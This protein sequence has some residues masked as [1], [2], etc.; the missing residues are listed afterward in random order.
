MTHELTPTPPDPS[1]RLSLAGTSGLPGAVGGGMI[2]GGWGLYPGSPPGTEERDALNLSLVIDAVRRNWVRIALAGVV[3]GGLAFGISTLLA[4][5]YQASALVRVDGDGLG[6]L[7]EQK[8]DPNAYIDPVRIQSWVQAVSGLDVLR[9]AARTAGLRYYPDFNGELKA[10]GKPKRDGQAETAAVSDGSVAGTGGGTMSAGERAVIAALAKAVTVT[11]VG[12][13]GVA[14]ID[15]TAGDP[16]VAARIA[17]AVGDAFIGQ[18]IMA[19]RERRLQA[20]DALTAQRDELSAR[21]KG[22]EQNIVRTRAGSKL[23]FAETN[24]VAGGVFAN[25]RQQLIATEADLSAAQAKRQV[26]DRARAGD[27]GGELT[28]MAQSVLIQGLR[29]RRAEA[30]VEL[31]DAAETYGP[32]HPEYIKKQ[33]SLNKIDRAIAQEVE[34]MGA[35]VRNDERILQQKV[36]KLRQRLQEVESEATD[37]TGSK[38][39]LA[40]LQSEADATKVSLARLDDQID[41]V[42]AAIGLEQAAASFVSRAVAPDAP[43]FP[44]KPLIAAAAAVAGSGFAF[45][46][47]AF[48]SLRD[49]RIRTATQL[50]AFETLAGYPV[51]AS[52]P[53]EERGFDA[54]NIAINSPY[55]RNLLDLATMLG[56]GSHKV[57]S[58]VISSLQPGD[59]G[60]S[61]AATLAILCRGVGLKTLLVEL[62]AER[63]LSRLFGGEW[64]LG[65]TD[66]A[67]HGIDPEGAIWVSD[68]HGLQI[69]GYGI[70]R[71]GLDYQTMAAVEQAFDRLQSRYDVV[72][73]DAPPLSVAKHA[74]RLAERTD[75]ML[76]VSQPVGSR[77][78]ALAYQLRGLDGATAAKVAVVF[79]QVAPDSDLLAA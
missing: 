19:A 39:Q 59:G 20:L 61:V 65:L 17:N 35:T 18:Q 25:I 75:Q 72:I 60:S 4:P 69:L 14:E 73:F 42:E 43:V 5:K 51:V 9:Q 50:K 49:R 74:C 28:E 40:R 6:V 71:C 30:A 57:G 31:S 21:L 36:D 1:R 23:V 53:A 47:V 13:S 41:T 15:A 16:T 26:L 7:E 27:Q 70:N 63:S 66:C 44:K 52:L 3:A 77:A 38:V 67:E 55:A 45:L 29:E 37:V 78:D 32:R 62:D 48:G 8:R 76:V 10:A 2:A 22:L 33:E 56:I 24:D 11:Q 54:D 12:Q 64:Q 46:M 68:R 79:N 34:R 58:V